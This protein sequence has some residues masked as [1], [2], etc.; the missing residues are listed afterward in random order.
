MSINC[1]SITAVSSE[2]WVP[3]KGLSSMQRNA[4]F[5]ICTLVVWALP[6]KA[7]ICMALQPS[8]PL[9][10]SSTQNE[11]VYGNQRLNR[12]SSFQVI[13]NKKQRAAQNEKQKQLVPFQNLTDP[14][15]RL[16]GVAAI[17]VLKT[18]PGEVVKEANKNSKPYPKF[19]S[20]S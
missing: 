6:T 15:V 11:V 4:T 5:C 20:R 16:L 3:I 8:S 12:V 2:L 9:Q 17:L 14:W 7:W 10:C 19:R 1:S 18:E 13:V